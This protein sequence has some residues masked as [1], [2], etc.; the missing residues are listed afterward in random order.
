MSIAQLIVLV[1]SYYQ[2]QNYSYY[3]GTTMVNMLLTIVTTITATTHRDILAKLCE[4]EFRAD[5]T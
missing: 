3:I 2:Y 4:H 5:G 1:E